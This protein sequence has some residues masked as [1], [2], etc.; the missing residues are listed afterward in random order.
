MLSVMRKHAGSWM[1]K[2]ILF[3]IVIVFV[4]WGVGSFRS[5]EATKVASVNDEII[6][7]TEYRRA[8]SN[9]IEQYRQQFGSS[10]NEGLIE[11][12]QIRRQALDQLID[13]R[14]ILQEAAKL[15]LRV[16]DV[17][18]ADSIMNTPVFQNNGHFD[19]R[20]Y[21]AMLAQIHLTPEEFE[22]EQKQ[23]LLGEKLSRVII[24]AAKVSE[25]EAR[26]W[27]DWQNSAVNVDYVRFDPDR[28]D[29]LKPTPEAI[30]TYFETHQETYKTDPMTRARYVV[31]DP[32]DFA[33]QVTVSDTDIQQYYDANIADFRTEKTVEARHVLIRLDPGAD[34]ATVLKTKERAEAVTRMARDGEDFA[35]LARTYSEDPAKDQGGY[36]GKFEQDQM[37]QPFADQAFAMAAGEISD[38][39]RTE[40]GWHVIKVESVEE[41][42]LRTLD[43]SREEIL[44]ALAE[45]EA[46]LLAY[47]QAE[48]FYEGCYD[49][50]D[51][52]DNA[53]IFERPVLEAGPFNRQGP[54]E[55]AGD[56]MAFA[57]AAF[58]TEVDGISEIQSI[59]GRYF[60][61]QP[62]EFIDAKIPQLEAVQ[63]R[64]E[65][66]LINKM[67]NNRAREEAEAMTADLR[68]GESFEASAE[69]FEVPIEQTGL[70]KRNTAIPDIGSDPNFSQA[71]FQLSP[72]N[73]ISES[74][75]QGSAG[76]Y[77]LRLAERETPPADG[78]ESE[79]DDIE[80]MLLR[81]KQRAVIQD[82][83][84]ARRNESQIVIETAFME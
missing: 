74:P 24:S 51:L 46:Q 45:R 38:P 42:S 60:I 63:F 59:G 35:E 36:L 71:A 66:D 23:V 9:L 31:F 16:T 5:Q 29:D 34:E 14:L 76:F 50:D 32:A 81:Q 48:L 56:G 83:M 55:L 69:K 54:E 57:D 70:F 53:K 25:D 19:N 64:V 3:A 82:W 26:L 80:S 75:V 18:V 28:Y 33:A 39:V 40:F 30:R 62:T 10:L 4:F 77:L 27:Y 68:A 2:V 44:R 20:R 65:A 43:Q 37:V 73:A 78:F 21:R 72:A 84:E 67:R 17:E 7:I 12:L 13:R 61:I 47:D 52:V 11:L 15:N 49:K 8:Y 22:A 58:A 41:A 6:T 1:I 79:K